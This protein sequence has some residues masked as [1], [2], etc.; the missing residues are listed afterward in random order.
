M[1][2]SGTSMGVPD[3]SA[4]IATSARPTDPR[5]NRLRPSI[6]VRY[7]GRNVLIDTTPDF[8]T[9]AL[10]AKINRLDAILFT[11]EHADHIMGLDDV[12]PFNFRQKRAHPHLRLGR[13]P[14]AIRRSS[15][16]FS[17]TNMPESS[18]PK[19]ERAYVER[20]RRSI[21]SAWSSARS[22][23]CTAAAVYGYRFGSAAYLTDHSDIPARIAASSCA[24]STCCFWTR[25]A[26]SRIPRTRPS[27]G[28][29]PTSSSSLRAAAYFTHICHDLPHARDRERAAAAHPA[30]LRRPGNHRGA[31][32]QA[33]MRRQ[34]ASSAVWRRRRPS[35]GP[36]ALTIGNFDGVH[37]GHRRILR[38]VREVARSQGWKPS[39]ADL[40][41]ASHQES[42]RRRAR[43]G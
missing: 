12:R 28:P 1:L 11:H 21:C 6:L 39:V 36:S 9:Q 34:F 19:L 10:R 7:G 15:S 20:R 17:T 16:T 3:S 24:G 32:R 38:R 43:R 25:C 27:S 31:A 22:G 18:I 26:T 35:F 8:R 40:R 37:A 30:G 33:E 2:G 29:S 13:D 23:C 42:S 5:D 4:A 14:G 41:S